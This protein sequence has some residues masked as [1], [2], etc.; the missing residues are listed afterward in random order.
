MRAV[1]IAERLVAHETMTPVEHA[2]LTARL[3]A[4]SMRLAGDALPELAASRKDLAGVRHELVAAG[5]D[6]AL[7]AFHRAIVAS[8]GLPGVAQGAPDTG[9]PRVEPL[10]PPRSR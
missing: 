3:A 2:Q 6:E 1:A 7:R 5:V 4:I 9:P 10:R 8:G